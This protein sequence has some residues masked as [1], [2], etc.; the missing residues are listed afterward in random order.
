MICFDTDFIID[1]L[2]EKPNAA[3]KY[4]ELEDDLATTEINYFEVLFGIFKKRELSQKE[5]NSAEQLFD[6]LNILA[7]DHNSSYSAAEIAGRLS[8]QGLVIEINDNLIAGMCV[9][10]NCAIL[11]KNVKHFSRIKGLKV[12]TY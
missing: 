6:T 10:K 12:E 1:L 11:T 5:L 2:R 8:K 9:S 3:A 4:E 7:L